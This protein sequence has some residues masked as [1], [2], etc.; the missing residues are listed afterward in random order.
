VKLVLLL[1][2]ALASLVACSLGD[3]VVLPTTGPC[4]LVSLNPSAPDAAFE[5]RPPCVIATWDT[6]RFPSALTED[7]GVD[8]PAELRTAAQAAG[9]LDVCDSYASPAKAGDP[10]Q[11]QFAARFGSLTPGALVWGASLLLL[12]HRDGAAKAYCRDWLGVQ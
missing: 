8:G 3:P 4:T 2:A 5:S 1:A 6:T 9:Y 7:G 12:D 10:G 11:P